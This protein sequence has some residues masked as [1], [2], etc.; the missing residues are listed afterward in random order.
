MKTITEKQDAFS[1]KTCKYYRKTL[2][3]SLLVSGL[4]LAFSIQVQAAAQRTT[5]VHLFEWNWQD[6]AQECEQYLG[7]KGYAAV[8]VSPPNEHIQGNQWWTRYQPVSYKIESRGGTR[9][10]FIDMVNRC[11]AVGVNIYVDAV[12]NHMA[13]GS[14]TGVAG[15]GFGNKNYPVYSP[16]DFHNTCVITNYNNRF[17]V[18]NCELVGLPDLNTSASYVQDTTAAYLNDLVN[19]G[20]AGFRL[21]ASKHIA[22]QDIQGILSKVNG[23]PLIFQEVIDQGGETISSSEYTSTGLVTEFKYTTKLGDTFRN[24][25][26]SWLSN[27]GEG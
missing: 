18:Q 10:Q 12:L 2:V 6:V 11:K 19:I 4:M 15:S 27:F 21:D 7:P 8:Q 3:K 24:G 9:A 23:A 13:F 5:F 14:G 22:V 25:S 16:Q 26:L 20:V 17:E 1:K